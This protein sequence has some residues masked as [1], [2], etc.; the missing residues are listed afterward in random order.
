MHK[1]TGENS[2][3][4]NNLNLFANASDTQSEEFFASD[5]GKQN[6][7]TQNYQLEGFVP[8]VTGHVQ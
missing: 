4:D 2:P 7:P 8:D 6:R 3:H 1:L 5:L